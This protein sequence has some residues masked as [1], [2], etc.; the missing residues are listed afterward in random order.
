MV[1]GGGFAGLGGG[2][3]QDGLGADAGLDG[4]FVEKGDY[5]E[6]FALEWE[7]SSSALPMRKAR[8]IL[9][10]RN[11]FDIQPFEGLG[12]HIDFCENNKGQDQSF[13]VCDKLG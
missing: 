12:C 11:M 5:V 2:L 1:F 13:E 8:A 9:T 3:F 6:G 10:P 7:I 4:G